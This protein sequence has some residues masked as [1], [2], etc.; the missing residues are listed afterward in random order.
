MCNNIKVTIGVCVRNCEDL[1][2]ETIESIMNQDF[3][4]MFMKVIFVDDG[5]ED[6][7]PS[8]IQS[9]LP[10]LDT[11]VEIFR[12]KWKGLGATRNVVVNNAEGEY[13]IWVDG[14]MR[15]SKDFVRKQVEFMERNHVV[16]IGKGKYG[17]YTQA[18]LVGD[19]ENMEFVATNFRRGGKTNSLPLGTGGSIYRVKAIKQID[20]F[21]QD[22]TG[23]G[24]DVD[25]EYRIR[26]AGWLLNVTSAVFYEKRRETWKSLW[27]EYFWHGR[28][29]SYLFE[30]NR[31]IVNWYKLWPPVAFVVEFFRVVMAY[32]LTRRKVALFLPFHYAFKRTAW[33]LGLVRS[34]LENGNRKRKS[35]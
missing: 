21:D 22:I 28:G 4:H 16:G 10:K 2:G 13:I 6:K 35:V 5:S 7:T 20:G 29:S 18:N 1:I 23:S 26:A 14:D 3:P 9:Y 34:L 12:H 31:Q 25:A 32:K 15:L 30:K 19:L 11:Q 24:E 8:I 33:F 27:N 17:M